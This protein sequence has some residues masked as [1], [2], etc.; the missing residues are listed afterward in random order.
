MQQH[1]GDLGIVVA[2]GEG[3]PDYG[4]VHFE[5]AQLVVRF[6]ADIDRHRR[7][8]VG[9]VED[10]DLLTVRRSRRTWADISETNRRVADRLFHGP[11]PFRGVNGVGITM[12]DGEFVNQIGIAPFDEGSRAAVRAAV[13]PDV[14]VVIH[15]RPSVPLRHADREAGRL[16]APRASSSVTAAGHRS[17]R[18]G[19]S[20]DRPT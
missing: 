1:V 8:L 15:R 5:G 12:I 6:T 17:C 20:R 2:Y 18:T 4:G 13:A 16:R 19:P 10:A 3:Q 9:R 7:I 14:V 11:T